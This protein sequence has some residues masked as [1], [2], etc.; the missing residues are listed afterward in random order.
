MGCRLLELFSLIAVSKQNESNERVRSRRKFRRIQDLLQALLE[1]HIPGVKH[2]L[3]AA[4]SQALTS[5]GDTRLHRGTNDP[6]RQIHD[7]L[8]RNT[9]RLQIRHKGWGD[10][11]DGPGAT[12]RPP[13][14]ARDSARDPTSRRHAALLRGASHEV[15]DDDTI[16]NVPTRR[17]HPS[18]GSPAQAWN[19]PNYDIGRIEAG[20]QAMEQ[21]RRLIRAP[22]DNRLAAGGR[23]TGRARGH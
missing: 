5:L 7:P 4:P 6:V 17:E 11:A 20:Q 13:L 9:Q 23:G 22:A 18:Q 10:N 15:L 1:A 19:D 14:E 8:T 2:D 21:E 12:K 3:F 16:R